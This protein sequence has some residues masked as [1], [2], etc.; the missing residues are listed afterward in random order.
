MP[1][2]PSHLRK[3]SVNGTPKKWA[4]PRRAWPRAREKKKGTVFFFKKKHSHI[5]LYFY[6][7]LDLICPV[8]TLYLF[9]W[10]FNSTLFVFIGVG[11][12]V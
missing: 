2:M 11:D 5:D 12:S 3:F 7:W 1:T 6:L 10:L 8:H 9:I 4:T